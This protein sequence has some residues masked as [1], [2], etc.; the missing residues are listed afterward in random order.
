ML[1]RKHL[2]FE[3]A[4]AY[5]Q[6]VIFG[7]L[8]VIQDNLALRRNRYV[9]LQFGKDQPNHHDGGDSTQYGAGH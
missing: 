2:E 6:R 5:L 8:K 3:F 1:T 4:A 9:G 7:V